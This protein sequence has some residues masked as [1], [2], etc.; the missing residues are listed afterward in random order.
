MRTRRLLSIG[1]TDIVLYEGPGTPR[2]DEAAIALSSM[3]NVH[4]RVAR[5]TLLTFCLMI[6]SD[7][8]MHP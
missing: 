7:S 3:R 5:R 1:Y 2:D 4:Y 8:Y 6:H